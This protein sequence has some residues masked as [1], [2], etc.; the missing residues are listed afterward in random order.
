MYLWTYEYQGKKNYLIPTYH[1]N[2]DLLFQKEELDNFTK[3]IENC[4]IVFFESEVKKPI[5]DTKYKLKNIYSNNDL[6]KITELI[7]TIFKPSLPIEVKNIESK[8]IMT[9][10]AGPGIGL[11]T[12]KDFNDI[13]DIYFNLLSKSKKKIV[14]YLD[15]GKKYNNTIKNLSNVV[16]KM[17]EYLSKNPP[18]IQDISKNI[19]LSKKSVNEFKKIFTKSSSTSKKNKLSNKF[20]NKELINNRNKIWMEKIANMITSNKSIVAF[21][22][23]NHIDINKND[24]LIALLAN[25]YNIKFTKQLL[26]D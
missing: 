17:K 23:A 15:E 11:L 24:N 9:L 20:N 22:G 5:T 26:Q 4:D 2:I 10:T 14:K 8:G 18:N 6:N 12:S 13:M 16:D 3:I 7:N 21:I 1:F 25:K 19:K